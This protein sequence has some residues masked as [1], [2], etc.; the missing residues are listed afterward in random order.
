MV[1][2]ERAAPQSEAPAPRT[3]NEGAAPP[4]KALDGRRYSRHFHDI[5]SRSY[6]H[7][8]A[9]FAF[10]FHCLRRSFLR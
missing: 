10:G 6:N 2:D 9:Q 4:S 3:G 1:R 7:A 5:N 8:A